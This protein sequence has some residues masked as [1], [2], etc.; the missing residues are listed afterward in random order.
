MPPSYTGKEHEMRAAAAERDAKYNE[1][2]NRILDIVERQTANVETQAANIDKTG[3]DPVT[4]STASSGKKTS[5][6]Y[7]RQLS[8]TAAT[9]SEAAG[10]RLIQTSDS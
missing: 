6:P 4:T 10:K 2:F 5:R 8:A 1:R 7:A 9:Q 3:R